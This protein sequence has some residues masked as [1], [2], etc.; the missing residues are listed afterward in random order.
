[1]WE[2]KLHEAKG[3][4]TLLIGIVVVL[5]QFAAILLIV[6]WCGWHNYLDTEKQ[7][8]QNMEDVVQQNA[9][10]LET[11]IG[12]QYELLLAL[13]TELDGVTEDTIEDRLAGFEKFIDKFNVK[14]FAYCFP[15]GMTYSTDG[16]VT[17]LSYREFYQVG[18][19]GKCCITN[20]LSD[21]IKD[22]NTS[23][24]VMTIPVYDKA[25][26]VCGVF[27]MAYDTEVFNQIMQIE[28]FDGNGYSCI[29]DSLGNIV[30]TKDDH[31][32]SL[33]DDIVEDVANLHPD[34]EE[35]VLVL[36][37]C[38]EQKTE[39][40]GI[41][42]MPE[43]CYYHVMPVSLMDSNVQFQMLTIVSADVLDERVLEIQNNQFIL[44]ASILIIAAIGIVTIV[45][46]MRKQQKQMI[47]F[48]YV[49]PLTGGATFTKFK[50]QYESKIEH[51]GYMAVM[52]ISD[53]ENVSVVLGENVANRIVK[54]IWQ[55]L[56]E[57]M[58][59]G[60]FACHIREDRFLFYLSEK[61]DNDVMKKLIEIS[62][63]ISQK[64]KDMSVYGLYA[65]YGVYKLCAGETV[66]VAY[67]KAKI[68][69]NMAEEQKKKCVFYED[70]E[71]VTRQYEKQLEESFQGAVEREE[72][73]V[74]Y[75]PK[76]HT[77]DKTMVGSEALVRWRD[78]EGKLISP[79]QFIPLFENN[80]MIVKLDEYMFRMVCRQ[81]KEWREEG[82]KICPVSINISKKSLYSGD[83]VQS[84]EKIIKEYGINPGC[85]QLEVTETVMDE[86]EDIAEILNK[87]RQIGIKIL[88]DDFGT[89]SSSL[90]MLCQQCF[91][92]LKID[93][94][95]I[96]H[97]GDEKGDNMLYHIIS[98]GHQLGMYVT[99]EG[100]E[101][102]TQ[103][104]ALQK[105]K[106]DDIQGF[107]FAKPM[108]SEEF[109]KNL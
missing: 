48:A 23:V 34:N 63:C 86:A 83:V 16:S 41:L 88:M 47:R 60:A 43:K 53:F 31:V 58:E 9:V 102:E 64:T 98:M 103:F 24:N 101:K 28:S 108:P 84:Y 4:R 77:K 62:G 71:R 70:T 76:Y 67:S 78:R 91:D 49:D 94:S 11:S 12:K 104:A 95:L 29:I 56:D 36:K 33:S 22:D 59:K 57:A 69:K 40:E 2:R 85:V 65:Q 50:L 15:G 35:E 26:K 17:E 79:G 73:E 96:D 99:A 1:M 54:E 66:D 44:V 3:N 89:G 109:E 20:G 68:A 46:V 61:T 80:G 75:Q 55:V 25:G 72:F 90:A 37:K 38:I 30:A 18:M 21:A 81:Q 107:Y 13:S 52:D 27:G 5:V 74:W 19:E 97:V 8:Y 32:F 7:L 14:R 106:C 39:A 92:V 6:F 42:W 10:I 82:K 100:V 45:G 93:K 87:F 105:M 51:A